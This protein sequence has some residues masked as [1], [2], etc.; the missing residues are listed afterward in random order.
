[1]MVVGTAA[2]VGLALVNDRGR[3]ARLGFG[4]SLV[5]RSSSVPGLIEVPDWGPRDF[6]ARRLGIAALIG[7]AVLFLAASV[8]AVAAMASSMRAR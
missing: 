6:L 2:A 5:A 8:P 7:V 1:M 4:E 3:T